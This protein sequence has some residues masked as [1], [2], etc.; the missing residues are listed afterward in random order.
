MSTTSVVNASGIIEDE[1]FNDYNN[2]NLVGQ[3]S[4][5][6]FGAIYEVLVVDSG[7]HSGKCV[8]TNLY[9]GYQ[10][11]GVGTS[12]FGVT[13]WAK[14]TNG[15]GY[16][17]CSDGATTTFVDSIGFLS[18]DTW[19]QYGIIIDTIGERYKL[20][21][22]ENNDFGNWI[23]I[24]AGTPISCEKIVFQTN[25][26]H[27]FVDD[28]EEVFLYQDGGDVEIIELGDTDLNVSVASEEIAFDS[29][30]NCIVNEPCYS[31]LFYPY[32]YEGKGYVVEEFTGTSTFTEISHGTFT[33][34]AIHKIQID[35]P[36]QSTSMRKLYCL[37]IIV[38]GQVNERYCGLD[39]IWREPSLASQFGFADYNI[40]SAC[41]DII[42]PTSTNS[43][44]EAF[45]I[46]AW[47]YTIQ[48]AGRKIVYWATVPKE[49]TF[50]EFEKNL[51]G[52]KESFPVNVYYDV[53]KETANIATSSPDTIN[54]IG[55]FSNIELISTSTLKNNDASET[56]STIYESIE[57]IIYAL[58]FIY[59]MIYIFRSNKQPE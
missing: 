36:I 59:F 42:A 17:G 38:D 35:F 24:S 4:W 28:I 18:N 33:N 34:Q 58:T 37:S 29:N 3:S 8:E 7:C 11:S 56:W 49:H 45:S 50:I 15:Y 6:A 2:G 27:F 20:K 40:A 21:A 55:I 43:W 54:M 10:K 12:L 53:Y 9:G 16:V 31:R 57:T 44:L 51:N 26:G 41:D 1:N 46:D 32:S 25:N 13:F 5:E 52:V 39:A 22:G 23:D 48:C 14:K 19:D 30:V 47:T